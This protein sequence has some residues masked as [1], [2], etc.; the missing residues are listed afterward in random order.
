MNEIMAS[1]APFEYKIIN[2]V[3]IVARVDDHSMMEGKTIV[4][5]IHSDLYSLTLRAGLYNE[6]FWLSVP[7]LICLNTSVQTKLSEKGVDAFKTCDNFDNS[8]CY[9][10][11]LTKLGDLQRHSL[12]KFKTDAF[13]ICDSIVLSPIIRDVSYEGDTSTIPFIQ[14]I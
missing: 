11:K 6:M 13:F 10:G 12:I 3:M 1:D 9:E 14:N 7:P 5:I 4:Y 8:W 2:D